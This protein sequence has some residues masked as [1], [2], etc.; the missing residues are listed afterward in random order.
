M[1]YREDRFGEFSG[2]FFLAD[3]FIITHI[4]FLWQSA[5]KEKLTRQRVKF[6]SRSKHSR[7]KKKNDTSGSSIA[8]LKCE[9]HQ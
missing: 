4:K 7:E 2:R 1:Y 3:Y 6:L 9:H 5:L 8:S